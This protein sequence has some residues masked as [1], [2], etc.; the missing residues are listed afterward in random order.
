LLDYEPV[1]I[2]DIGSNSVRLVVYSGPARLPSV[3]FNEKVMAGLGRGLD[4]RRELDPEARARA[5][6]AL[7]R[8]RI[9]IEQMGVVRR[10]VVATAAVRDATN[11]AVFLDEVRAVGFDPEVLS[12]EDEGRKAGLGVISSI[13][14][15]DGLV[16]DLGGG[17]LELVDVA[18]GQVGRSVSLP[19][20][21]F[22]LAPL[23]Q[24]SEGALR[25]HVLEAL[26][27]SG[28]LD[29]GRKRPFYLVGGSWRALARLDMLLG[30]H[31]LPITHQHVMAPRRPAELREE[32]ARLDKAAARKIPSLSSSRVPTLPQANL[33]LEVLVEALKPSRLVTSSFG[34]REGLLFEQ[35]SDEQRAKDPLIA[36]AKAAGTGL[37]RFA[38]HGALLDRWIAP[39]FDDPPPRARLRLAACHLADVAWQAHPEFR[40]ERGLDMALHGNWVGIDAAERVLLGQALFCG[41]G[42]GREFP[43]PV[44]GALTKADELRRASCWGLAMRLGQRLSAGV[45]QGLEHS[46][47][48]LRDGTLLLELEREQA[49]LYGDAVDRRFKTLA[50]ALDVKPELAFV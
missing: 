36:A 28:M 50:A 18:G 8:F 33:L 17:S 12:G 22:R 48:S 16:G 43:D 21:V 24:K 40:A 30:R 38:Q 11:G 34:I 42:G 19:L 35:L 4:G 37:G 29:L 13:P 9:L 27:G 31:P 15:A 25:K 1:A 2:V 10:R 23:L 5:L 47:V 6:A 39:L 32:I 46:R 20:G 3:I 41:F 49:A 45:R 26:R 7:R 14:D 44:T